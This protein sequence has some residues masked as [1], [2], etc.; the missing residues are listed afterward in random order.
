MFFRS[1]FPVAVALSF[2]GMLTMARAA[3]AEVPFTR[4]KINFSTNRAD[5]MSAT[6]VVRPAVSSEC[7]CPGD[8]LR[9]NAAAKAELL[10]NDGSLA[11]VGEQ[12]DLY[13]WPQTRQLRLSQGTAM[14][15]VSPDQGRT[16]IQTANAL[17]G[18]Q[19]AAVVVRYVPERNLTLV[20]ALA[21]TPAGPISLT[22]NGEIQ[23]L[24]LYAGQMALVDG[25]AT[26][27]EATVQVVEFDLQGFYQTSALASG[28]RLHDPHGL[29][30]ADDP[31]A[32]LRPY[33]LQAL[34][35][36]QP[37]DHT[38]TVVNPGLIGRPPGGVTQMASEQ[39]AEM[40]PP[41]STVYSLQRP[42]D[43]PPGVIMPLPME[44]P[45]TEAPS[46]APESP[47]EIAAPAIPASQPAGAAAL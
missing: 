21:H 8:R 43:T 44:T 18:L 26:A 29:G 1:I 22:V 35:Q 47:G 24:A 33:L 45:A 34:A 42:N 36:Q 41:L 25:N 40:E 31:I 23:E 9:T 16:S 17:V 11:R 4:A 10:F 14:L 30:Q 7:L 12:S 20:M 46:P 39:P 32:A 2:S 38:S 37:F 15:L 3:N 27:A 6:G 13:F 5:L 19:D 28:L